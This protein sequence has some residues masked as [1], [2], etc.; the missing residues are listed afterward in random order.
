MKTIKTPE[1]TLNEAAKKMMLTWDIIAFKRDFP[2]LYRTVI[3]SIKDYHDQ[4]EL[5]DEEIESNMRKR[6]RTGFYILSETS[7]NDMVSGA[8]WYKEQLKKMMI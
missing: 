6:Y 7:I 3:Y 4:F 2:R 5:S 1:E 8:K